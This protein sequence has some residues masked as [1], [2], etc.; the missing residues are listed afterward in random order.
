MPFSLLFWYYLVSSKGCIVQN[1]VAGKAKQHETPQ[2]QGQSS[3]PLSERSVLHET[4]EAAQPIEEELAK[5]FMEVLNSLQKNQLSFLI[6]GSLYQDPQQISSS[7][8][9]V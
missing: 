6:S 7:E 9:K 2:Q 4:P 5:R 1:Q 3:E 8:R